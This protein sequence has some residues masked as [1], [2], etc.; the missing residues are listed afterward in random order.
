MSLTGV[1]LNELNSI[2]VLNDPGDGTLIGKYRSLV[3]RDPNTRG[4]AGRTGLA[5]QGKQLLG[6]AVCF[7]IANPS[8]GYGH[9]SL[10]TWSGWKADYNAKPKIKTHWLLT[11]SILDPTQEWGSTLI[12]EDEFELVMQAPKEEYLEAS[13]DVLAGLLT[14]AR[15]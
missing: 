8:Q 12:G 14:K 11:L 15:A 9:Y 1:W 4:L 7:Q 3:G 5:E 10:C 13:K 2:M 6:F